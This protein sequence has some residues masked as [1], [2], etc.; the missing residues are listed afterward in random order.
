MVTTLGMYCFYAF[1]EAVDPNYDD[2]VDWFEIPQRE[3]TAWE[4]AGLAAL[5]RIGG[6]DT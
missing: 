5:R 6:G 2:P 1:R 3:R 4:A